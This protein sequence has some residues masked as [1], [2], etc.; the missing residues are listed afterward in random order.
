MGNPLSE[1][2]EYLERQFLTG[3][4][5][6]LFAGRQLYGSSGTGVT[7]R[8]G[9][10]FYDLDGSDTGKLKTLTA[11]HSLHSS[12]QSGID[13]IRCNFLRYLSLCGSSFN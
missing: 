7:S 4:N 8:A 5:L 3:L 12:F 9:R 10:F 11:L 13:N 2:T 1:A 6:H